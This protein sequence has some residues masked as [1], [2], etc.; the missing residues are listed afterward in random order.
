MQLHIASATTCMTI[1]HRVVKVAVHR[2]LA[3]AHQAQL[4]TLES[5]QVLSA[6]AY[7]GQRAVQQ[8]RCR[9]HVMGGGGAAAGRGALIS[10]SPEAG[11]RPPMVCCL[12]GCIHLN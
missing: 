2:L 4:Q 9:A 12:I 1:L 3:Q 11:P 10:G 5:S 8:G 7:K 6:C